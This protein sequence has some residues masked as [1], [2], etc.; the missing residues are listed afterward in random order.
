MEVER[1]KKSK[2]SKDEEK[3]ITTTTTFNNHCMQE[4][5][6]E[7]DL[8]SLKLNNMQFSKDR[9]KNEHK[10]GGWRWS[11]NQAKTN[12]KWKKKIKELRKHFVSFA[13]YHWWLI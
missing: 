8:S 7:I 2:R 4:G 11:S 1:K 6:D 13:K 10:E 3:T 5:I 9:T 12:K